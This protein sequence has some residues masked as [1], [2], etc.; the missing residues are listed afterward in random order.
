MITSANA[1]AASAYASHRVRC[2]EEVEAYAEA[3]ERQASLEIGDSDAR[4]ER[5]EAIFDDGCAELASL[6]ASIGKTT[7]IDG[8][9]VA[10]H[11]ETRNVL[12]ES[13]MGYAVVF[14]TRF[15]SRLTPLSELLL[16]THQL[17]WRLGERCLALSRI[18]IEL[19]EACRDASENYKE[20][21]GSAIKVSK[22]ARL[23]LR[24]AETCV[25][26]KRG[27]F[28]ACRPT[29]GN[30]R[31]DLWFAENEL[32]V[33]SRRCSQLQSGFGVKVSECANVLR[34]L[35]QWRERAVS[36]LVEALAT[37]T[38]SYR[39]DLCRVGERLVAVA[40]ASA[41]LNESGDDSVGR[42]LAAA[43]QKLPTFD[44]SRDDFRERQAKLDAT[45]KSKGALVF[46]S[47]D[48]DNFVERARAI[49]KVND[50]PT[51]FPFPEAK[52][53]PQDDDD[54]KEA[55]PSSGTDDEESTSTAED[56]AS[57]TTT[58]TTTTTTPT[59]PTTPP[60]PTLS[61]GRRSLVDA[62]C[63]AIPFM[64]QSKLV[65]KKGSLEYER[66]I[67]GAATL[68]WSAVFVILTFDGFLS[69]YPGRTEGA[70]EHE[71]PAF[72]CDLSVAAVLQD[73][74][75][76]PVITIATK[77]KSNLAA[78]V[79]GDRHFK[80]RCRDAAEKFA[81]TKALNDPLSTFLHQDDDGQNTD[82]DP[83]GGAPPSPATT[84][85]T[86]FV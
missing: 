37:A 30:Q 33:A 78:F 17:D 19:Q 77:P 61:P 66:Q 67:I 23:E 80:L 25:K 40:R 86:E 55:P 85:A 35:E 24:R 13:S 34:T 18:C 44:E 39:D 69:A 15:R 16:A 83:S 49:S 26:E 8:S 38:T 45:A 14:G 57:T 68:G 36:K 75:E 3:R 46:P 43:R 42:R 2:F 81:W 9:L 56:G 41:C 32:R 65:A 31:E 62:A 7:K 63:G 51:E 5:A 70:V 6:E 53:A 59:T 74:D 21:G 22:T 1:G 11:N 47:M 82:D 28:L 29:A 60:P 27:K 58:T 64:P 50:L 73:D 48:V 71:S 84:R 52:K 12:M 10:A 54:D 79:V 72:R 76:G 4:F 20:V